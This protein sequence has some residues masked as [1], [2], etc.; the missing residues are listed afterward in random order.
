[1]P[2]AL[3][4]VS[5]PLNVVLVHPQIPPNTGNIARLCACTGARL[6]LVGPL[7]FSIADSALKRAGLDYWPHVFEKL[8]PDLAAFLAEHGQARMHLFSAKAQR[9]YAR[10]AYRP[11]D[12][13]VFG[14]E[15]QGL[16]ADFTEARPEDVWA[17]PMLPDRRSLNLSTC[18]GIVTYEALRQLGAL[19]G[20]D[21]VSGG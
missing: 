11:G 3:G 12:F 2:V 21:P 16:P 5:A 4:P 20:P 17:V 13:L 8:Y 15:T 9:S 14:S 7:G 19:Q 10:A 6:H 18:A 1:M